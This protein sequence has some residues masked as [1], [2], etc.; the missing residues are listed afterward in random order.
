M[1]SP[2]YHPS[3]LN[4]FTFRQAMVPDSAALTEFAREIFIQTFEPHNTRENMAHY[5][6]NHLTSRHIEAELADPDNVFMLLEHQDRIV[7]Y[8]KLQLVFDRSDPSIPAVVLEQPSVFLERF[9]V[10]SDW[11]GAGVAGHLMRH[12]IDFAKTQNINLLW[13]GVWENNR[14]ALR[15]YEKWNFKRIGQHPFKMGDEVQTD[16]W[17][18]LSLK[19]EVDSLQIIEVNEAP[20]YLSAAKALFREYQETRGLPLDFQGF[21]QEIENLPGHFVPPSGALY[22]A[23]WDGQP[24]GC[25]AFYQMEP[26]ICELKRLFVKPKAQGKAIGKK[27][28]ECA[29]AEAKLQGYR[30]MRLDSL[31]R[32]EAAGRLYPK[33]GFY[34]IPPYNDNPYP[35]VYYM[36]RQL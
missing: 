34:E 30:V 6:E 32:F 9:Y 12:C 31:R 15:F 3:V 18:C 22:V 20:R 24:V 25:V 27:L 16:Y 29:I 13:L 7:A 36:E 1:L 19:E 26:E 10:G 2:S 35:D 14:R 5:L 8:Y 21:D 28:T 17:M 33:L 4:A 11:H 23:L